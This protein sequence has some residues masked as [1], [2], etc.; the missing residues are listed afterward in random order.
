MPNVLRLNKGV[1][2][3]VRELLRF[4]LES[5]KVKGVFALAPTDDNGGAAYSL[6]TN[7][8]TLEK[9]SPLFPLMPANRERTWSLFLE[10]FPH[11]YNP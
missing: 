1:E 9:T 10:Y 7:L 2:E 3:G 5:E 11:R 4:L 6:I 8:D